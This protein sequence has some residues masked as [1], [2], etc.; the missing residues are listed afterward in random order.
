MFIIEGAVRMVPV[1]EAVY[2]IDAVLK[3]AYWLTDRAYVHVQHG[4][5]GKIELRIR[6]ML[7]G[8][9]VDALAG[10]FL[11]NLLEQRLRETVA[12]ETEKTRDLI[13]GHALSKTT[14]VGRD[15]EQSDPFVVFRPVSSNGGTTGTEA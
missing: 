5:P 4:P 1:E 13:L 14:L 10:E 6:P 2:G 15:L 8:G 7:A 12:A 9:D 3:A 11:N